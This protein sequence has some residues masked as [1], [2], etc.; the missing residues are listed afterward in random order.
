MVKMQGLKV[1][2]GVS[3]PI[4]PSD[5]ALTRPNNLFLPKFWLNPR[6][7]AQATE[8][9]RVLARG[10]LRASERRSR[11]QDNRAFN[12]DPRSAIPWGKSC[13]FMALGM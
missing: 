1:N 9:T 12:S 2:L 13:D 6:I 3:Y 4:R 5:H 8:L 10:I 11:S 7:K